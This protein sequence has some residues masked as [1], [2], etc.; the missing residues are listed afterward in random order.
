MARRLG[1]VILWASV[2]LAGLFL[3]ALMDA[4]QDSTDAAF[5]TTVAG[6]IVLIGWA[7]RYILGD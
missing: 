6:S 3:A 1:N 7:V 4:A 2:L 5:L